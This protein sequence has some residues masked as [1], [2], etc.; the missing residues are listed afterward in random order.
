MSRYGHNS[1]GAISCEN[2][3]CHPDRYFQS[4][5][6]VDG[7]RSGEYSGYFFNVGH[8]FAL[9]TLA[10]IEQVSLHLLLM[11]RLCEDA[12]Q[13]RFGSEHHEGGAVNRIGTGGEYLYSNMV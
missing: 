2:I 11:I 13:F 7:I 1:S 4:G 9:G 6:G 10:G 8:P 5:K 12:H 3:I